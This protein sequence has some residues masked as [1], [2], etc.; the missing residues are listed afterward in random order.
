MTVRNSTVTN[1]VYDQND[2]AEIS[3][4]TLSGVETVDK[5]K[6]ELENASIGKFSQSN[7]GNDIIVL[8]SMTLTG[9]SASNYTLTQPILTA[10]I[11]PKELIITARD[12]SKVYGANYEFIQTNP[13][14]F[15]VEGLIST[16][17]VDGVTL[18]SA[19]SPTFAILSGSP[20][21]IL[22]GNATGRGLNNYKINYK[23]GK[24][25]ISKALLVL[26]ADN[27]SKI[28]GAANPPLTFGYYGWA[29]GT[30][31]IT[32]VPN[33][34]TLVSINSPV[35]SYEGAITI[36]GG[37]AENYSFSYIPGNMT[38]TKAK[39]SIAFDQIP[40]K[41]FGDGSFI[42][43]ASASSGLPVLF[44]S[45]NPS[46]ATV[47]GST[48]KITGAGICA[49]SASQPGNDFYE[50]AETV[51]RS[52]LINT[53]TLTI[54]ADPVTKIYGSPDPLLTYTCFGWKNGDN[55]SAL[56]V[57]PIIQLIISGKSN[58][59]LFNDALTVSGAVCHNYRIMYQ[60]SCL[61]IIPKIVTTEILANNKNFDGTPTATISKISLIGIQQSDE[62]KLLV[63]NAE[64]DNAQPGKM[65]LVTASGLNLIGSSAKNYVLSSTT[66]FAT[67]EIYETPSPTIAGPS[68]A[69]QKGR[70]YI[71]ITEGSMKNYSWNLSEGGVITTGEG[72]NMINVT[73]NVIGDQKV[74]VK[75]ENI[76]GV[77]VETEKDVFVNQLPQP[78]FTDPE[79]FVTGSPGVLYETE[80][81]MNDYSWRISTSG[82]TKKGVGSNAIE[83]I[84]NNEGL[85]SVGVSHTNSNGCISG[86]SNQQYQLMPRKIHNYKIYPV[87][88]NGEFTISIATEEK[89][90]F[91]VSIYSPGGQKIYDIA[92][93]E[94]YGVYEKQI[95]LQTI[96]SG[97]YLLV[98][99]SKYG[100]EIRR[101]TVL[102][103]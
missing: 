46:V 92:D 16:D 3:G 80:T 2:R 20:Y 70:D 41:T 60:S 83:V 1:K 35:G 75:Y 85:N 99:R 67:A 76:T 96:T 24:L 45:S 4:A 57:P 81:G 66:A 18:T 90:F 95:R 91:G 29:N 78:V 23:T 30:E 61:T 11:T 44:S 27:K 64:F 87:P 72:T 62:V 63:A 22:P 38:V 13:G 48:L 93:L 89:Q 52:Q 73:W 54:V 25:A 42:L 50:A 15:I 59:G 55:E 102:P 103:K 17:Y 34:N 100:K 77:T 6:V 74:S 98:F 58:V 49:I 82:L 88:N 31:P 43:S 21:H 26:I 12:V 9:S 37:S 8:S 51:T 39:Q 10:N 19:G 14:D 40:P 36:S 7:T 71:Y 65:K 28:Y 47:S 32:T 84:W 56:I 94:V 86:I 5:G 53:A 101:M 79:L 33:I 69:C 97:T 68:E